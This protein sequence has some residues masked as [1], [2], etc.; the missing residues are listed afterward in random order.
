MDWLIS[1]LRKSD[2]SYGY[3]SAVV[4]VPRYLLRNGSLLS[5]EVE[6]KLIDVLVF[7]SFSGEYIYATLSESAEHRLLMAWDVSWS[8]S[9][10]S[11]TVKRT[12]KSY[13][14]LLEFIR[15]IKSMARY[16]LRSGKYA[17]VDAHP[18]RLDV[19]TF[20]NQSGEFIYALLSED[21]ERDLLSLQWRVQAFLAIC[22]RSFQAWKLAKL[23]VIDGACGVV[24]VSK[25]RN[26]ELL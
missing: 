13:F 24:L 11:G 26:V 6:P 1:D 20:R 21:A 10:K 7:R 16:L 14:K 17:D 5:I 12:N 4:G 22:W 25:F 9:C 15:N 23:E 8:L 18:N 3:V 2:S 19:V